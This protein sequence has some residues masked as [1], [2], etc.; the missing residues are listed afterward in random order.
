MTM[1]EWRYRQLCH[2]VQS[3]PQPLRS[4]EDFTPLERL[5]TVDS[6][7]VIISKLYKLLLKVDELKVSPLIQKWEKEL[8]RQRGKNT[9]RKN[10]KFEP[11]LC[12][13][14]EDRRAEL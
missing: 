8:G 10:Y 4:G 11:L 1:D 7:K 3:L 12:H 6:S 14:H 13:R 9:N 5:C 2:F